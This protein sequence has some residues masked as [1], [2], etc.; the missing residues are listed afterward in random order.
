LQGLRLGAAIIY[1]GTFG[2]ALFQ[3]LYKPAAAHW[4]MLPCTLEWHLAAAVA[5][6]AALFWSST[7]WIPG[8]MLLLSVLV[9]LL[10]ASQA[11]LAA[12]HRGLA[13][14]LLIASL[15]YVQPLVRSWKRYQTRLFTPRTPAKHLSSGAG[16]ALRFPFGGR[17]TM[18]YWGEESQERT[19]LLDSVVTH[20][21]SRRWAK[22]IDAGWSEWD[23]TV[24]C[25]RW[26]VVQ[27]CT[28]QEDHGAG[29]RLIRLRY[30]LRAR[31]AAR[32]LAL[33]G[34]AG[35]AGV[36]LVSPAVAA[37]V[38]ILFLAA[39]L[40]AWWRGL[41][42]AAEVARVFDGVAQ[43]LGLTPCLPSAHPNKG[44]VPLS[45]RRHSPGSDRKKDCQAP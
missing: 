43:G 45:S 6:L 31:P 19:Q 4:A 32:A 34:V 42:P 15:C 22:V 23:L 7:L 27:V 24:D 21:E 44:M 1:R 3:C 39:C 5:A 38:G 28:A 41:R 29:K 40:S 16:Q 37:A 18:A 11:Q 20:L 2:T 8:L 25:T 9:A 26:S 17:K 12:T 14:R 13:A 10:H 36:V 30:R 33:A 35:V